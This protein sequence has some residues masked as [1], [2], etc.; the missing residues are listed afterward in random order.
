LKL[1]PPISR[2]AF[3]DDCSVF[4]QS[5]RAPQEHRH[6]ATR[7]LRQ[8]GFSIGV[9]GARGVILPA[10]WPAPGRFPPRMFDD[11]SAD[12]RLLVILNV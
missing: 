1:R 2:P 6:A 8:H 5:A 12:L 7:D 3:P 11:H 9:E 10:S 4:C